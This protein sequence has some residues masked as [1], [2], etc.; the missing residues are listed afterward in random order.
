MPYVTL[1]TPQDGEE[2]AGQGQLLKASMFEIEFFLIACTT[3]SAGLITGNDSKTLVGT[4]ALELAFST[5]RPVHKK[6]QQS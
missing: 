1:Q 4:G 3:F 6:G 2:D 5:C